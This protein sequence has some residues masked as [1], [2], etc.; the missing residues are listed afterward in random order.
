MGARVRDNLQDFGCAALR[1]K[2]RLAQSLC[3]VVES[4]EIA[5][6]PGSSMV[7]RSAVNR[8]VAGSSPARGANLPSRGVVND[9]T[10]SCGK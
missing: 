1:S 10:E 2:S 9:R 5:P 3:R 8:N 7:E 6:F 4:S